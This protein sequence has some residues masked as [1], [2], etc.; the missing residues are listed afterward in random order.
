MPISKRI[1]NLTLTSQ[2]FGE[3]DSLTIPTMTTD[4]SMAINN[5]NSQSNHYVEHSYPNQMVHHANYQQSFVQPSN[6]SDAF[7][8]LGTIEYKTNQEHQHQMHHRH[9]LANQQSTNSLDNELN[10]NG[11]E[12]YR[13]ELTSDENPFYFNKNKLLFDLHIERLRRHQSHP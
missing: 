3:N 1:N 12:V 4:Y 13:P 9:H 11:M 10:N 2:C 6:H 8:H 5:Q 7:N